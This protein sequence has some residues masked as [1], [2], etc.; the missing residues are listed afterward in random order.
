MADSMLAKVAIFYPTD[1]VGHVPSGIDS[2]IRGILKWAPPDLHYTLFGATSDPA[3]RPVGREYALPFAGDNARFVPLTAVN[4]IGRR[5]AVPLTVRYMQALRGRIGDGSCAGFDVLDFHRIEPLLLFRADRRPKNIIVHQDMSVL[6]E[7]N[8]D[9]MWRHAPW[10]YEWIERRLFSS[11]NH[12]FAVRQSAVDRYGKMYPEL[13]ARISFLPTWVDNTTFTPPRDSTERAQARERLRSRLGVNDS[14]TRVLASVGRLDKQK[15][16]LLLLEALAKA[17]A[18]GANLHV[19]MIGDG[20]LRANVERACVSLGLGSRVSL[21]GV[22][23]P[24]EIAEVLR[25]SDLFVLSS[26]YEGMPIAVLEALST[27]LPVVSTRVGEVSLVIQNGLSGWISEERTAQS[28]AN[29]ICMA[30]ADLDS[31]TGGPCETA[32]TPY[33]PEKILS[34]LYSNHRSQAVPKTG[35]ERSR[36][37]SR[38]TCT[39]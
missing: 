4:A 16:P 27:G 30:L 21:M 26:A 1:P 32:V 3:A 35:L 22:Q 11:L 2:V 24:A 8:C 36:T 33:F 29:A 37:L 14:A 12:I 28:L 31:M 34:L 20:V 39:R 9:I 17:A 38:Y 19:A 13:A 15:D 18:E 23:P 7:K 25:G 5:G 10:L 6:R